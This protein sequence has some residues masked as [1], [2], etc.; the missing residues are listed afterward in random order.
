MLRANSI[1]ANGEALLVL[2]TR[3]AENERRGWQM[4]S[5]E[6]QSRRAFLSERLSGSSL[7]FS[8]SAV[9]CYSSRCSRPR[10]AVSSPAACCAAR[11]RV[12]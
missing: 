3:K 8:R 9:H 7:I 11:F 10:I 6:K 2:G 1:R 5:H 12:T 4:A